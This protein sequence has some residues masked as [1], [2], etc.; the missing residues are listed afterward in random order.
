M[1]LDQYLN[2]GTEEPTEAVK[3]LEHIII[4]SGLTSREALRAHRDKH[5]SL[6]DY[7]GIGANRAKLYR[8][9]ARLSDED[10][11][12][13]FPNIPIKAEV[14]P[15]ADVPATETDTETTPD[16][17]IE[18]PGDIETLSSVPTRLVSHK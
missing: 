10:W 12:K 1:A 16:L 3:R 6:G 15:G 8:G 5:P 9:I 7:L 17:E 14:M 2:P 13:V 11:V 4:E 18:T